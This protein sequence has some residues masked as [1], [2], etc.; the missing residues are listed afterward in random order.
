MNYQTF[1][2]HFGASVRTKN[3]V[4]PGED[5][6]ANHKVNKR[7]YTLP[8]S[9]EIDREF[10]RLDPWEA[11]YLFILAERSKEGIV[12]TG[13]FHG[14]STFTMACANPV[15]PIWSIDIAPQNDEKLTSVFKAQSVGNNVSLI[16]GDSQHSR[17]DQIGR[18]D[19]LF[20][21][22]DHS[23]EGCTADL[24]N[25]FPLLSPGGHVVLHDSYYGQ[26]VMDAVS[27]F[28]LTVPNSPMIPAF[29]GSQHWRHHAGSMA[30]FIK[31]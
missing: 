11:E 23:Y 22:G 13:R 16:V 5:A 29:R 17:Y 18:F 3:I 25:W 20:I 10:I 8:P 21:D 19:L 14:G 27:D 2:R 31:L 15:A 28:F 30:H 6:A 7:A 1:V 12:E 24:E 26:P 4:Q 9:S